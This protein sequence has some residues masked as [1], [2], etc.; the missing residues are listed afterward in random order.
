MT[1]FNF[2]RFLSLPVRSL[3]GS[4]GR[5]QLGL[6]YGSPGDF[7]ALSSRGCSRFCRTSVVGGVIVDCGGD[8]PSFLRRFGA[9]GSDGA[10]CL[11]IL[12]GSGR[13]AFVA[14]LTRLRADGC[15]LK[16]SIKSID[17]TKSLIEIECA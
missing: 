5:V 16:L 3:C 17:Y 1:Y 2:R 11:R 14:I 7:G 15:T 9:D 8:V 4:D 13:L 10:I 12:L 6:R